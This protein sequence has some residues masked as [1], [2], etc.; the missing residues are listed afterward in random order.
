MPSLVDLN[1]G[2]QND[3]LKNVSG[4]NAERVSMDDSDTMETRVGRL[5]SSDSPI[6]QLNQTKA[7]QEMN[8]SGTLNTSMNTGEVIRAGIETAIP[9]AGRDVETASNYKL[10]NQAA[11][12]RASEFGAG[13]V[14]KAKLQGHAAGEALKQITRTGEE[15]RQTADNQG[16][17]SSRLQA[18][19]YGQDIGRI[20]ES[21]TQDR[22]N[23]G[24]TGTE[25]RANIGASGVEDRASIAATGTETRANIGATG[26]QTRENI[27][28]TGDQTRQTIGSQTDADLR[29]L[30]EASRDEL[31]RLAAA[32]DIEAGLLVRRSD[33][34]KDEMNLANLQQLE[35]MAAAGQIDSALAQERS[36][37][38][39][40]EMSHGTQL[41]I[42]R[43]GEGADL[44][45]ILAEQRSQLVREEQAVVSQLEIERM[46]VAGGIESG[47]QAERSAQQIEQMGAAG[48]I[49]SQLQAERSALAQDE[50]ILGQLQ[51]LEK[52][53]AAGGI[54]GGLAQQRSDLLKGE[55]SLATQ[56]EIERMGEGA[57]LEQILA[58]QRSQLATA[59]QAA[60]SQQELERLNAAG[61]IESNLQ[62]ER[63]A[64]L[65]NEMYAGYT[66]DELLQEMKGEQAELL[67]NIETR[68]NQLMQANASAAM[69]FSTTA[70]A[71]GEIL[72]NADIEPSA[73][74]ALV[75]QQIN[76]L[77]NAMAVEGSIA[78][79]DLSDL[80]E[81]EDDI[82]S[83]GS[84]NVNSLGSFVDGVWVP[85]GSDT[86]A[87]D[88]PN[89]SDGNLRGQL[90]DM[91]QE[92]FGRD[93]GDDGYNTYAEKYRN[94]EMT[95]DQIKE[96]LLAS[97]EYA[98][99]GGEDG[100]EDGGTAEPVI[101]GD[102]IDISDY[103]SE[104]KEQAY[105][106]AGWYTTI[107][108]REVLPAGLKYYMEELAKGRNPADLRAE[109]KDS[110][111][112]RHQDDGNINTPADQTDNEKLIEQLYIDEL[113]R[114]SD[115]Q[116]LAH[117]VGVLERGEMNEDEIRLYINADNEGVQY[118]TENP[119]NP[120]Y[121]QG[122]TSNVQLPAGDSGGTSGGVEDNNLSSFQAKLQAELDRRA[123]LGL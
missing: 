95:M 71:I 77:E 94:N 30:D 88:N 13:E 59:E 35:Q 45:A 120:Y 80:L 61:D 81:F 117:W 66:Y 1:T 49:E 111:E 25:T 78:N 68:S 116:G 28:A 82:V 55:M 46:G 22:A 27:A 18:E 15:T 106:I 90:N 11:G 105:M 63:S 2:D 16:L 101:I 9:I 19:G 38:L 31:E 21:G 39:Q 89:I 26:E 123:A 107:L 37:L 7:R 48:G 20:Q 118:D 85:A 72:A 64:Q 43:M 109:I 57:D 5:S 47:L 51:D 52:M 97:D 3:P 122:G 34:L 92:V 44:E 58:A 56:Q 102:G 53:A 70:Q 114:G 115:A 79:L 23:I 76:L 60:K 86:P 32:G 112:N 104:E 40:S 14:N 41:E 100:G 99:G 8:R 50:M 6:V 12:N 29:M 113:G 98:S 69:T 108:D 17:I 91:Y 74:Q 110:P 93:V 67:T 103:T 36:A 119:D 33:L 84:G 10:S 96:A 75:D 62:Y 42:Q 4:Y 24:A 121:N 65:Q 83:M 73:K 87:I 54:E